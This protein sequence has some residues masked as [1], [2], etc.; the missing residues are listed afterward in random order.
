MGDVLA[1]RPRR[2]PRRCCAS[3]AS[4]S[5][6][7]NHPEQSPQEVLALI[8]DADDVLGAAV[9]TGW[10]ATQGYD[11]VQAIR[12]LRERLF[13]VHLKDVEAP[14]THITCMHGEGVRPGSPTASTSCSTLGYLGAADASSTSRTTAIRRDECIRMREPDRGAARGDGRR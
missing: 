9:D 1:Q 2:R 3:T 13:H 14:G 12:D 4:G 7:E 11:P 5:R 6:Y 8:G 10:W